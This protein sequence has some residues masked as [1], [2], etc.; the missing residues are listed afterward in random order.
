MNDGEFDGMACG[1]PNFADQVT[2]HTIQHHDALASSDP[3]HLE[4]VVRLLVAQDQEVSGALLRGE[5]EAVHGQET[6][7]RN[8]QNANLE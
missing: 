5:V 2:S 4:R 7:K 3:E 6:V 8:A 1:V